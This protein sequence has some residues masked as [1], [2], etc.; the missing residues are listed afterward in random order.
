M[1]VPV[2]NEGKNFAASHIASSQQLSLFMPKSELTSSKET[3]SPFLKR[4]RLASRFDTLCLYS[5]RGLEK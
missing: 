1:T 4:E 2:A 5:L 3:E